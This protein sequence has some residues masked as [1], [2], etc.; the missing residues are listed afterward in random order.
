MSVLQEPEAEQN[1]TEPNQR[2]SSLRRFFFP[3]ALCPPAAENKNN[4][5]HA[6]LRR[7][8]AHSATAGSPGS[9]DGLLA[10]EKLC[11]YTKIFFGFSDDEILVP[12]ADSAAYSL[13]ITSKELKLNI[14]KYLNARNGAEDV[15]HFERVNLLLGEDLLDEEKLVEEKK[16]EGGGFLPLE[17]VAGYDPET[18]ELQLVRRIINKPAPTSRGGGGPRPRQGR[19]L[20]RGSWMMNNEEKQAEVTCCATTKTRPE[21]DHCAGGSGDGCVKRRP[22]E[23]NVGRKSS[24]AEKILARPSGVDEEGPLCH[25]RGSS[26]SFKLS[27][28]GLVSESSSTA[29]TVSCPEE[30]EQEDMEELISSAS[31]GEKGEDMLGFRFTIR[32]PETEELVTK[33]IRVPSYKNFSE[34]VER[35]RAHTRIEK[36]TATKHCYTGN[37]SLDYQDFYKISGKISLHEFRLQELGKYFRSCENKENQS[38]KKSFVDALDD[39][40]ETSAPEEIERSALNTEADGEDSSSGSC[41]NN[42]KKPVGGVH[43]HLDAHLSAAGAICSVSAVREKIAFNEKDWL[44]AQALRIHTTITNKEDQPACTLAA[45]QGN[46]TEVQFLQQDHDVHPYEI[47]L[48]C[49]RGTVIGWRAQDLAE[50]QQFGKQGRAHLNS[51]VVVENT[52]SLFL[53]PGWTDFGVGVAREKL[54]GSMK[55]GASASTSRL[56]HPICFVL[57]FAT[58]ADAVDFKQRGVPN[59]TRL[60]ENNGCKDEVFA[61]WAEFLEMG[62]RIGVKLEQRGLAGVAG[63]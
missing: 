21:V 40:T 29:A 36:R 58:H 7:M 5:A 44:S 46:K 19:L 52:L 57:E 60:A 16:P 26:F 45:E 28:P 43:R 51:V 4:D 41:G 37:F 1:C 11:L 15:I 2:R 22:M 61:T 6:A 63:A 12:D 34:E 39:L 23:R 38:A 33:T 32:A 50:L 18:R 3:A 59:L 13:K 49:Y 56:L 48:R 8:Q 20:C 42:L 30:E 47:D 10:V 55:S 35:T 53:V 14:A 31:E 25:D 24:P 17:V 9:S 62:N 54:S 27:K